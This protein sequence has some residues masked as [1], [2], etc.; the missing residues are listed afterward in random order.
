MTIGKICT[1]CKIEKT[2]DRFRYGYRYCKDCRNLQQRKSTELCKESVFKYYGN[3]CSC[4][5]ETQKEFLTIDHINGGGSSDRKKSGNSYYLIVQRNFP[6]DLQI[7]C[8]NCNC[9]K[10]HKG[11]CPHESQRRML[12]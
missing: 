6:K 9:S 1:V 4:C 12:V 11:Y 3:K 2:S 7:L 5:G 10:G 8:Y